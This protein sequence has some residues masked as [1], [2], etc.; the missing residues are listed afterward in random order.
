MK[1]G[2]KTKVPI[3]VDASAPFR[4][5]TLGLMFDES[6]VAVRSVQYGDIY[7]SKFASTAALPYL[8]QDGKM[9]VSLATPGTA[10]DSSSGII[11]YVEIEALADGKPVLSFDK[12]VLNIL[13]S[14]GK[15]FVVSF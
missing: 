1:K 5:A 7:G 13:T 6:K 3:Y 8:N 11:A 4:T 15:N 12:D 2:E 14:N 9:F 10:V